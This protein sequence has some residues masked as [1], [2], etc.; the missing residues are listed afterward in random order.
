MT[1]QSLISNNEKSAKQLNNE[2]LRNTDQFVMPALNATGAAS[3]YDI[4]PS[5]KIAQPIHSGYE[6]LGEYILKTGGNF[7]L[8]GYGAV[9]WDIIK[10]SLTDFFTKKGIDTQWISIENYLKPE[11]EIDKLIA[12]YLGGGDPLFGK[13]YPGDISDF[14]DTDSIAGLKPNNNSLTFVYGC[15]AALVNWQCPVIYFDVPKNEIQFRSR[16]GNTCN[17]GAHL[18]NEPK[19]QYKRFY[20]IDW[21]V[22]NKHKQALLPRVAVIVDEQRPNEVTWTTGETL[23]GA[24]TDMSSN[25]FRARPWFEPGV[26][27]G[28]WIKKHIDGLNKDVINYAWSFELIAPENGIVLESNGIRLEVSIDNLLY[29]NN[30]LILGKAADRFGYKFP[31]RFD[32]LDTMDG[33]NLSLQC[34]PT[35][36]YTKTNFGEDFTQDETYYI[37]DAEEDAEVYLGFQEN[38]DKDAFKAVLEESFNTGS[39]I[40]VEKYVQVFPAKKHDLFLIPNGTVHCSGKNNMVLEISATPY[41]FTFKMYDWVRPDLSGNP[42]TLNID[43][44]FD[45]LN[46]DRKG[47]VVT[48]TLIS[49]QTVVKEGADW[50]LISLSTHPEH[51]YNIER[52]EFETDVTDITNNQCLILSLVEGESIIVKTGDLEQVINYAETFIVPANTKTYSMRNN[53]SQKAKVV[54]AY[55]KDECC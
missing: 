34:H 22:F 42:R 35:V 46:F 2:V 40:D 54:K 18:P 25:A 45:N 26:W 50:R 28:Q 41:I 29:N 4:Y 5:F 6:S 47:D 48:D 52:F 10:N 32:F 9:Y 55:V 1:Y 3:G 21:V 27:G 37:L 16:A 31:I 11:Q 53:G 23:R 24:L 49:K 20:F 8:D 17:L 44:A 14:Y 30:K 43:R 36:A 7:I 38:I 19:A 51:F 13:I 12:P 33:D 15:G 39:P